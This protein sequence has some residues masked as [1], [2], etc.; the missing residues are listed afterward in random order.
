PNTDGSGKTH[1]ICNCCGCSCLATRNAGMFLH[2][3]FVRSNYISQIDKDKCVACGECV[4]VCPDNALKLGQKLCT[5]TPIIEDKREEFPS[6]TEWG[7]DKWN[8]DYRTNREN[9]VKTGTS[10]CKTNCP[11][12]IAV[13]G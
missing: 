3:D 9:V 6:N 7:L 5:K 1:A 10:P 11:A 12:H 8:V 4:K 2:N 13:Q